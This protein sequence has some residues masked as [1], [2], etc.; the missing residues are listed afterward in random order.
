MSGE[1]SAAKRASVLPD[2][3]DCRR[4]LPDVID[5][6]PAVGI[7]SWLW[8]TAAR[9]KSTICQENRESFRATHLSSECLCKHFDMY[10]E[11]FWPLP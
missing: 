2:M 4:G 7:E 6:D 11:S 8:D 9:I 5:P 1:R 10:L 3:V